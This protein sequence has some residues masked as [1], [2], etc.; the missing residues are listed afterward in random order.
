MA[1]A[2]FGRSEP[3]RHPQRDLAGADF[4]VLTVPVAVWLSLSL[5][6]P[7]RRLGL[8]KLIRVLPKFL[9][10]SVKGGVDV[11]WRSFLPRMPVAPG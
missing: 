2:K 4:G 1:S 10:G 9:T 3:Q 11:A 8:F 5:L 6:P 7:S